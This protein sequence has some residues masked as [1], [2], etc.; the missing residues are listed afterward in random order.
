MDILFI[1]VFVL[2][3]QLV[4]SVA[5]DQQTGYNPYPFG[6]TIF[7]LFLHPLLLTLCVWYLGWLWGILIFLCHLFGIIHMT[8]SWIFDIPT[9]LAKNTKQ[10]INFMKLKIA[11]LTPMVVVTLFF[12][13]LSFLVTDYKSLFY[14]LSQ[15]I[16]YI[17][18]AGIVVTVFSII[19]LFVAKATSDKY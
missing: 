16:S 4:H 15:N 19:R 17:V 3:S 14:L 18:I 6:T 9:L 8:V 1:I 5:V 11:I 12:T 7:C 2:A 10:L 13:I